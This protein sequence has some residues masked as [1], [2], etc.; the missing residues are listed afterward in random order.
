MKRYIHSSSDSLKKKQL[1]IIL[2][3]NPADDEIHTWIR[4][5]DDILTFAEAFQ[6]G[7]CDPDF[8]DEDI[9]ESLRTGR[10]RV[11][12]SKPIENGNFVSPSLLEA[13]AYSGNKTVYT[14]IVNLEDVAWIDDTQGQL[15]CE[16]PVRYSRIQAKPM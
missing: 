4:D 14:A 16:H 8:T 3:S 9:A 5:I 7:E 2:E 6:D 13:S 15:A 10:V 11:Y 12:S 1:E